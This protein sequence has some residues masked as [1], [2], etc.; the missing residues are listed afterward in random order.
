[1]QTRLLRLQSVNRIQEMTEPSIEMIEFDQYL[2]T[3]KNFNQKSNS[4]DLN[5]H[6]NRKL[7]SVFIVLRFKTSSLQKLVIAEC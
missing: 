3:K 5:K 1:M 2:T 7:H 4:F 6:I